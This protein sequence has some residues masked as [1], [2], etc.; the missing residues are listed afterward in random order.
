MPGRQ[1]NIRD[2]LWSHIC[3]SL[4]H[5]SAIGK[6]TPLDTHPGLVSLRNAPH[7]IVDLFQRSLVTLL[8]HV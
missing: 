6:D 2:L 4:I 3:P 8:G 5:E 1:A 7:A